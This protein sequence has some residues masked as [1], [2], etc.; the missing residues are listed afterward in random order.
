MY[1]YI[2]NYY[3]DI[4]EARAIIDSDANSIAE[5][6]VNIDDVL[7]QFSVDTATWGLEIWERFVGLPSA[8]KYTVWDSMEQQSVIFDTL[9]LKTWDLIQRSFVASLDERRSAVKSRLRG[10]GT[11]TKDLIKSVCAAYTGGTVDIAEISNEFRVQVIFTDITGVPSNI[12][13]LESVIRDIMP[14]HL[15]VEYVYRYLQWNELDGYVWSW[16]T[17]DAKD[18]TWDEFS[19]AIQ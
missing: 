3:E 10:T 14:A 11:V 19:V 6:N 5:I 15:V 17:L 8:S 7:A 12:A 13:A 9:E 18:Y 2:P 16:D 1:D 4:R